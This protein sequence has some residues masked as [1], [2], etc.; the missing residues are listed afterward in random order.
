MFGTIWSITQR[1]GDKQNEPR[2]QPA[3]SPIYNANL[4]APLAS[5]ERPTLPPTFLT[6]LRGGLSPTHL[7]YAL[8]PAHSPTHLS[9]GAHGAPRRPFSHPPFLQRFEPPTL[10]PTLNSH[11]ASTRPF[12]HP[13]RRFAPA[14]LP[15]TFLAALRAAH[16]PTHLSHGASRRPSHPS[17]RR[18]CAPLSPH[19][20]PPIFS[21]TICTRRTTQKKTMNGH[22][23]PCGQ[24]FSVKT[25]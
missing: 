8:R 3:S 21:C 18:R 19:H 9:H 7:S 2:V 11:G 17:G 22:T 5:S 14:T 23:A 15:P 20:P 24:V 4:R 13:P 10:A 16:S 1:A 12:S 6:A 25:H